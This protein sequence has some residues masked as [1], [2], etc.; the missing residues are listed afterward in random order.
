MASGNFGKAVH[1]L[2]YD[3]RRP[4]VERVDRFPCLKIHIRILCRAANERMV[5][6]Q[7]TLTMR[8]DII[9]IDHGPDLRIGQQLDFVDFVR[10]AKTVEKMQERHPCRQRRRLCDQGHVVGFLNRTGAEQRKAGIA[11]GHDIAMIAEY[12]QALGR[13]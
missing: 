1:G 11:H 5:G 13:Q 8:P 7:A 6:T 2:L 3:G 12:R 9:V 10:S 4:F